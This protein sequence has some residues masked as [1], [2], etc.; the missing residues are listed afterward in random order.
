[1]LN[2]FL[3][4]DLNGKLLYHWGTYGTAPGEMWSVHEFSGDSEGNLYTAEV[5][6]GRAQK[7]APKPGADPAKIFH[8][9]RLM[10]MRAS[11]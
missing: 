3:K 6:G 10:P 1:M 11:N 4:Y 5:F 2:E 8:Q 7:F 9:Q